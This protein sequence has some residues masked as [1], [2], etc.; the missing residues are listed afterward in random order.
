MDSKGKVVVDVMCN[1]CESKLSENDYKNHWSFCL[2]KKHDLEVFNKK[3]ALIQHEK[4]VHEKKK[5]YYEAHCTHCEI[6]YNSKDDLADHIKLKHGFDQKDAEKLSEFYAAKITDDDIGA[7]YLVFVSS[8]SI[9][10]RELSFAQFLYF[11]E[12]V[13]LFFNF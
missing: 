10:T 11:L 12:N 8:R 7:K 3:Q 1:H 6:S 5:Y 13:C 9:K 2:K 4:S